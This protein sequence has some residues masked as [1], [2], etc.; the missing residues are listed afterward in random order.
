MPRNSN[1]HEASYLGVPDTSLTALDPG[2]SGTIATNGLDVVRVNPAAAR[3]ACILQKGTFL[4]QEVT[5]VN[6]AA[7]A[8]GFSITF[9]VV[10]NSFVS[11][12]VTSVIAAANARCFAWTGVSWYPVI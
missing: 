3:A 12:G 5:V 11:N 8:S 1:T 2:A 9:D 10:A 6:E 7:A 4:G